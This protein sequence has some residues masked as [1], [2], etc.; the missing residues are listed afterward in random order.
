MTAITVAQART[1]VDA[2]FEG[3]ARRGVANIMVVVTD[4]GGALKAAQ[5]SDSTGPAAVEIAAAKVHTALGFRRS[6]M[7]LADFRDNAVVNATLAGVLS[8]RFMPMGGGVVVVDG[9]GEIVGGAAFSGAAAAVDHEIIAEAVQ[10]AGLGV[11]P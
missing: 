7:A 10:T 3:A 4:A 1:I 2:A 6:T 11:L 9:Q 5:R 8:G